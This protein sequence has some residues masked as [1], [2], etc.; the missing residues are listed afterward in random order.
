MAY[1]DLP[2]PTTD[3]AHIDAEVASLLAAGTHAQSTQEGYARTYARFEAWCRTHVLDP[4]CG[5]VDVVVAF[6]GSE[7]GPAAATT[8]RGVF[9]AVSWRWQQEG[10][11]AIPT[12][13]GTPAWGTAAQLAR[14]RT[15]VAKKGA[16]AL[17]P[18]LWARVLS[19]PA[20]SPSVEVAYARAALLLAHASGDPLGVRGRL[21]G[22]AVTDVTITDDQVGIVLENEVVLLPA[23]GGVD[24][25]VAAVRML[26]EAEPAR[27]LLFGLTIVDGAL[28][29]TDRAGTVTELARVHRSVCKT[30]SALRFGRP[31]GRNEPVAALAPGDA[32]LRLCWLIDLPLCRWLHDQLV[33]IYQLVGGFRPVTLAAAERQHVTTTTRVGHDGGTVDAIRFHLHRSKGD[34]TG[35]G[36]SVTMPALPTYPAM[37]PVKLTHLWAWLL[38]LGPTDPLLPPGTPRSVYR[39][40][41]VHTAPAAARTRF[42]IPLKNR[43]QVLGE[44]THRRAGTSGRHSLATVA[45]EAGLDVLQIADHLGQRRTAS[46]THYIADSQSRAAAT[47]MANRLTQHHHDRKTP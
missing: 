28:G 22:I 17:S 4:L 34:Q 7:I 3:L 43:L 30:L 44:P 25:P 42:A 38:G 16:T 20:P 29:P 12:G 27:Q 33:L 21:A 2:A 6:C 35:S 23:T 13:M 11:P 19:I 24:C 36:H 37:C 31:G 39:T 32:I 18:S 41:H 40:R 14:V 46:T 10:L 26:L 15:D 45:S 47:Q 5:D 8:T 1:R 9:H